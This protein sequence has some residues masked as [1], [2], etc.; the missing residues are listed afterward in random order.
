M[1]SIERFGLQPRVAVQLRWKI[2]Q[3]DGCEEL[4]IIRIKMV[5]NGRGLQQ[6]TERCV[7]QNEEEWIRDGALR[8]A[9]EVWKGCEVW[10]VALTENDMEDIYDL[11]KSRAMPET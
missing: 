2:G 1:T 3:G 7:V 10:L 5:V 6:M 8:D 9:S 11:S 4:G